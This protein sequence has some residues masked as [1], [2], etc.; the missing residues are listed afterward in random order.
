MYINLDLC[1]YNVNKSSANRVDLILECDVKSFTV[2][3]IFVGYYK[4]ILKEF[5]TNG[6]YIRVQKGLRSPILGSD[7]LSSCTGKC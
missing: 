5:E 4:L 1:I 7:I 6:G 2:G 3:T